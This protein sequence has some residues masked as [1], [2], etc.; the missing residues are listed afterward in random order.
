[1]RDYAENIFKT[2]SF[3]FAVRIVKLYQHLHKIKKEFVLSKQQLKSG[4]GAGAMIEKPN[5]LKQGMI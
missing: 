4:T 2:K 5:M 3:L 1:M